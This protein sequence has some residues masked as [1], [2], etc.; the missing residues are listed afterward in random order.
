MS[1]FG[2]N[3]VTG[4]GTL[5]K[6]SIDLLFASLTPTRRVI[7][8]KALCSFRASFRCFF[9]LKLGVQYTLWEWFNVS[10]PLA[11]MA[12]G[13]HESKQ[14]LCQF[15]AN[16]LSHCASSLYQSELC[17]AKPFLREFDALCVRITH[18]LRKP[19]IGKP[20]R[21]RRDA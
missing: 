11:R 3:T 16:L 13:K 12:G 4:N 2:W 10:L 7:S 1:L 6:Y 20:L 9:V 18:C 5:P 8:S 19:L 21:R 15:Y 14:A 17:P